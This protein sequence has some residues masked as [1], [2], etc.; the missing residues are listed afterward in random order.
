MA[1]PEPSTVERRGVT[2]SLSTR[3]RVAI[4]DH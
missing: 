2:R 4:I 3:T 1:V